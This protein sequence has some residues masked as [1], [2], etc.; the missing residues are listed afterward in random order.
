MKTL[1]NYSESSGFPLETG[2]IGEKSS[3]ITFNE[4]ADE[5]MDTVMVYLKESSIAKYRNIIK[6]HLIPVFGDLLISDITRQEILAFALS[7]SQANNNNGRGLSP[8]SAAAVVSLLK[9]ILRYAAEIKS[10]K[11]ASFMGITIKQP[12]KKIRVFTKE[13]HKSLVSDI[14]E[15]P[16]QVGYGILLSLYAG[17]RIGEICALK[18]K[19]ID[20]RDKYIHVEYT[21]QRIQLPEGNHPRTKI[22]ITRPK[23]SCSIRY[24][25]IPGE[26]AELL[27]EKRKS[28]NTY[29]LTGDE[30]KYM[31]PRTLENHFDALMKKHNINDATMHT[32]RHSFATRCVELGFD[33]KTLSEI[34]GHAN[35]SITMDRYVHPSMELKQRSMEKLAVFLST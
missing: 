2:M 3:E 15:H 8:S 24:I 22:I 29:F 25:P 12:Q 19:N 21:M 23:S 34:L 13:E 7:L 28:P 14:K 20:I 35:V 5:W 10:M 30:K 33:I 17:L 4:I 26:L 27:F 16:T 11:T 9:R 1:T 18:W 31:E 32:C 6:K